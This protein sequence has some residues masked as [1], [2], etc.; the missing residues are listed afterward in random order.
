MKVGRIEEKRGQAFG[1]VRF[2]T[3]PPVDRR[4]KEVKIRADDG[5]EM[6]LF[7]PRF[8]SATEGEQAP[9]EICAALRGERDRLEFFEHTRI[10]SPFVS[11]Q[12]DLQHDRREQIVEL[13]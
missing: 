10:A 7:V 2:E 8:R 6:N 9:G 13:V 11:E 5:L 4:P 3:N 12:V 1:Q